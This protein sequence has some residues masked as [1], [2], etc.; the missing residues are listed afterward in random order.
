[1]FTVFYGVGWVLRGYLIF[2]SSYLP[3]FLGILMT[4]GSLAFIMRKL[5]AG[6]HAGVRTRQPASVDGA[7]GAGSSRVVARKGRERT[8]ME[9]RQGSG[10]VTNHAN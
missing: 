1:M 9:G 6:P 3:K 4:L 5:P 2:R 7:W 10:R 8:T